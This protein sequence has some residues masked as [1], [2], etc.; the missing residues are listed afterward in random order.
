[1]EILVKIIDLSVGKSAG[2]IPNQQETG[3]QSNPHNYSI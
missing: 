3:N 2:K 1:M